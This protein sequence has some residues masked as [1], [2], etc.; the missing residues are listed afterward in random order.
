MKT[1][2][3]KCKKHGIETDDSICPTCQ[4]QECVWT[5]HNNYGLWQ[6]SCKQIWENKQQDYKY[7]PYCGKTLKRV[8][9][10]EE[11]L[12]DVDRGDG[13]VN[14]AMCNQPWGDRD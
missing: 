10:V 14:G 6:V 9:S 11:C 4:Q 3:L 12:E 1:K 2:F 8:T 5:D 7:C 13:D